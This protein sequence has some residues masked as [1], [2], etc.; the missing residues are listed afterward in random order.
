MYMN[1]ALEACCITTCC[2]HRA[3]RVA[4]GANPREDNQIHARKSGVAALTKL[5]F[6]IGTAFVS[7]ASR[8][9]SGESSRGDS[10]HVPQIP[11]NDVRCAWGASVS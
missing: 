5:F 7:I 3:E 6:V 10:V 2:I 1:T 11:S 8:R 9:Q 4:E